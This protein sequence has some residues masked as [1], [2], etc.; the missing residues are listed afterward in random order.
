MAMTKEEY[1]INLLSQKLKPYAYNIGIS[2]DISEGRR[3][4]TVTKGNGRYITQFLRE[5]GFDEVTVI[6]SGIHYVGETK[7]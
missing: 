2:S 3:T 7:I 6:E 4:I 1:L 5:N